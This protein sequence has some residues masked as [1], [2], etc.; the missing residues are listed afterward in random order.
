MFGLVRHAYV[1]GGAPAAGYMPIDWAS[2]R[3]GR[4]LPRNVFPCVYLFS[5]F[6]VVKWRNT[7]RVN[8]DLMFLACTLPAYEWRYHTKH[9]RIMLCN[10]MVLFLRC[11]LLYSHEYMKWHELTHACA[12]TS[13]HTWLRTLHV[14]ISVAHIN[15]STYNWQILTYMHS[16][17][18][19]TCWHTHIHKHTHTYIQSGV[20]Q[21]GVTSIC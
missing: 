21:H 6:A 19:H 2:V 14:P 13:L 18:K 5:G 15:V 12:Q 20:Q 9:L 17:A 16:H 4:H 3:W 7:L 10:N 11:N 8:E 1:L